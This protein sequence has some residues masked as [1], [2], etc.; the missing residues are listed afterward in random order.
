MKSLNITNFYVDLLYK[1]KED[2]VSGFVKSQVKKCLLDYLGVTIAG[3]KMLDGKGEFLLNF[4]GKHKNGC[5]VIGFNCKTDILAASL[6]NGLSAHIADFDDGVR[7]ASIHPGASIFSALLPLAQRNKISGED[8]I[9]G[10]IVGYE[11]GIR[12]ATAIQPSHRNAGYHATGTCGTIGVAMAISSALNYSKPQMKNAL[13]AACGGASGMLNIIK[14]SSELKPYNPAKAAVSGLNAAIL[15]GAD[16]KGP[17]DVLAGQWGFLK[18]MTPEFDE[19][20]LIGRSDSGK[21]IEKIYFKPY[22][23]CRHCHPVIEAILKIRDNH[24]ISAKKVEKI[25]IDTYQLAKG[26]HDHKNIEGVTSAK[27]STPYSAAVALI[28][29]KADIYDFSPEQIT[30]SEILGLAEKVEVR[31]NDSMN[32]M[33]PEKRAAAV[34]IKMKNGS[35]FKDRV[36]LAKG[37]PENPV[38]DQ[39]LEDKFLS[40]VTFGGKSTREAE[41]IMAAVKSIDIDLQKLLKKL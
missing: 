27:M 7:Q 31:I 34:S 23:A 2:Q 26:G 32:R 29:G 41:S 6:I 39:E 25:Y 24:N 38:S 8:F 36:D 4:Y 9:K 33:V 17:N 18:M 13:S 19:S 11:A 20:S 37:E 14:G 22:A 15:S 1:T 10:V 40:L 12:L 35:I 30:N 21:E 3:A 28:N 16:F 5:S